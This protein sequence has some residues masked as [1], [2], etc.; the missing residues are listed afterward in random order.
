MQQKKLIINHEIFKKGKILINQ[1]PDFHERFLLTQWS[2]YIDFK[3]S[4]R[5]LEASLK[6]P[7]L[8]KN[9]IKRAE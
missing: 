3:I 6:D 2:Q 1:D 4:R 8:D 5:Q 9:K 7:I